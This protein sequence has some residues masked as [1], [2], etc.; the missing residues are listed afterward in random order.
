MSAL[1]SEYSSTG[2]KLDGPIL[3]RKR[4]G[5]VQGEG[6]LLA[7]DGFQN[8]RVFAGVV[9]QSRYRTTEISQDD[10]SGVGC[11]DELYDFG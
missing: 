8:A 6:R 3:I 11:K 10:T 5:S 2:R 1:D 7:H 4:V 9:E